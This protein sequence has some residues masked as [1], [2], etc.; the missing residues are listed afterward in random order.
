MR[1]LKHLILMVLL[2][3]VTG[4]VPRPEAPEVGPLF[5]PAAPDAPRI[6]FLK[7]FSTDIDF[8]RP[9]SWMDILLG[10][11]EERLQIV[12]PYGVAMSEDA[13]Y[14]CDTQAK[15]VW[16]LDL[17]L[18]RFSHLKGDTGRGKLKKPINIHIDADGRK[19]VADADR[20]Q[21]VVFGRDGR[22]EGAYGEKDQFRPV[23]VLVVENRLY[24]VDAQ[25]SEIEI[26]DKRTGAV[27]GR[28]GSLGQGSGQFLHPTNIDCG[29]QNEL[30]VSDTGNF[31]IQKF[32]RD[33]AFLEMYGEPG[34]AFGQF[35]RPKGVAVDPDGFL[36]VVDSR[37]ENIQIFNPQWQLMMFFGGYGYTPGAMA[38]PAQVTIDRDHIDYFRSYAAPG[39]E[40]NYLLLVSNQS[41]AAK[42]NVYGFGQ[43][44]GAANE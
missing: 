14:V 42:I 11:E 37:F 43:M 41:G 13:I 10:P 36:Y 16:V 17:A 4:C 22:F 1:L 3:L 35:A 44:T 15:T 38:L 9:A 5:F 34:Q 27:T 33:G 19:F 12:K 40:I 28:F 24:V 25:D 6:Q 21:V 7:S 18:K 29:P 23:D 26:L 2:I 39:F 8:E 32:D 20:G 30:Y 31:R